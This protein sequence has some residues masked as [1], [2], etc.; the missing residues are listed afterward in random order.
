METVTNLFILCVID[1][2]NHCT[3][4][5]MWKEQVSTVTGYPIKILSVQNLERIVFSRWY[6][7]NTLYKRIKLD[8]NLF[9]RY[10]IYL[11]FKCYPP[12]QFSLHKPPNTSFLPPSS[13]RVLT[14]PPIH[15]LP[16]HLP[17]ISL[18]WGIEFPQEREPP[19][20][21]T[22]DKS[23]L[24]YINNW[25]H[26]SL[27]VY[28]LFG[29]LVPGSSRVSGSCCCSSCGGCKPLQLLQSFL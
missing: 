16:S 6:R 26:G 12:F 8:A 27:H 19:F 11:H 22:P 9:I 1:T 3:N 17:G 28:S 25:S 7:E 23:M 10:F 5:L 29:G 4:P 13:M 18:H 2:K 20:P 21:L 14:H 24:C 15:P